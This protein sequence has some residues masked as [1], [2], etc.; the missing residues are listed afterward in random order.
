MKKTVL[1]LFFLAILAC[2]KRTTEPATSP[3]TAPDKTLPT[4]AAEPMPKAEQ[5]DPRTRILASIKK[6]PCFGQCPVFSATVWSDG[7]VEYVGEKWATRTGHFTA[8][9]KKNWLKTLLETAES[10]GYFAFSPYY[11]VQL[12]EIADLPTTFVFIESKGR[13]HQ[14]ENHFDAPLALLNF[15]KYFEE[16]LEELEWVKTSKN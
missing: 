15:E 3:K 13:F 16:K 8:T 9:A 5:A 12:M 6:T 2:H 14:V 11:P 1:M 4:T 10:S 7:K